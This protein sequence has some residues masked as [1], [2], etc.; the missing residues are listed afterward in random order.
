MTEIEVKI[1]EIDQAQIEQK[2]IDLGAKKTFDGVMRAVF[3]DDDDRSIASKGDLLR[4]RQEGENAVLA[5][6]K[7]IAQGD[8]KIMEELETVVSDPKNLEAILAYLGISATRVNEKHRT[9]YTLGDTH[10]VIDEY[11]GKLAAIPVF[12]EVEAP[13]EEKLFKMVRMLG[14]QPED[15]KNWNTRDLIVHYGIV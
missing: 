13:D 12:L 14:Y 15:C 6:K 10:V 3:F 7:S 5:Y 11:H 1:L 4:L 8:T 2:L 9:E